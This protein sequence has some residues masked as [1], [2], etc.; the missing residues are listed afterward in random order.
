MTHLSLQRANSGRSRS[1]GIV[2]EENQ[3]LLMHRHKLGKEYWVIPGG[4]IEPGETPEV[5]MVRELMEE[6][7][8]KVEVTRL[9]YQ[10]DFYHGETLF[11]SNYYFLGSSQG[12]EPTLGNSP[13]KEIMLVS[14]NWYQPE[15][16]SL[17]KID[18]LMINPPEIKKRLLR[19]L[20][21]NWPSFTQKSAL[22]L[23]F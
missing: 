23:D 7:S 11:Y 20:F 17:S 16:V 5:A 22:S 1:A 15:W 6:T 4:G 9:I 12:G 14:E 10:D 19:D 21:S 18:Q 13:E 2:V 3:I 8:L